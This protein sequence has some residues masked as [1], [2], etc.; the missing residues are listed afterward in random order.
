MARRKRAAK[1]KSLRVL[2]VFALLAVAIAAAWFAYG[3]WRIPPRTLVG[4][5]QI[6]PPKPPEKPSEAKRV[7]LSGQLSAGGTVRDAQIGIGTRAA[8]LLRHVEI[9]DRSAHWIAPVH[10][11][12]VPF[13]E[14]RFVAPE[15]RLDALTVDPA[16][17]EQQLKPL[18]FP[19]KSADLPP[20]MAATFTVRDGVL[21]A[22]GDPAHPQIGTVRISYRIIPT[23]PAT[24][25]GLQ[26]GTHLTQ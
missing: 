2:W 13:S 23:G 24:L 7:T 12:K 14:A 9:F 3:R 6:V 18:D 22:G 26:K 1:G 15:I 21:Y 5:A 8:V 10:D 11:D 17:A 20:N 19:V 16:L 4:S 25:S